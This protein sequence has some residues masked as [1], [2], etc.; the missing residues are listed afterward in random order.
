MTS[1]PDTPISL[2][3]PAE[4]RAPAQ[5]GVRT[6]AVLDVGA[7]AIRMEIAELSADGKV[8]TLESL[9]QPV[10][11]GKDTFTTGRIQQST[12][13]EC[14]KIL[15]GF[16]RVMEEYGVTEPSQ[17]RAVATSSVREAANREMFLDRIYMATRVNVEAIDEAE[18]TRLTYLAVQEVLEREPDLKRG[19]ALVI[20]VGGGDTELLLVQDGYVTY[21]NTFRLGTLRMRET[22]GAQNLAAGRILSTFTKHI[23]LTVDQIRRSVPVQ[24]APTLIALSGDARFAASQLVPDWSQVHL[25]RVDPKAFAAFAKKIA[26]VSPD[27]LVKQYRLTY[28]EAETVG[29][30]LLAFAQLAKVFGVDGILIPKSSL[31][32]GLLQEAVAGGLW[33]REFAE[34]VAHSAIALGTKYAFDERHARQVADLALRFF[35]ELQAEHMLPPRHELLL[36]VAALLHEIGLFVNNRS[37]HKHSMYLIMNS[38]LFGLSHFDMLMIAMIARY[39]RRATPQAYHEG[40]STLSRDARLAVSKMAA[41]LR[42]ADALDRNHMQQV[43][44][45]RFTREDGQFVVW[46][47][48][49]EDLTLERLALR[50]K[51]SM[52]EEVYGLKIVFRTESTAEGLVADV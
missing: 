51:G 25:A 1:S 2:P 40:F 32:Y 50:E 48:D 11:L 43:R 9:Q 3:A 22:L 12:I 37:H 24:K 4:P 23:Q 19:D 6:A 36:H 27:E 10:H 46:V 39:H 34:Q 18:E 5:P 8:R 15:K 42:V 21:A 44:D 52:F 29:P 30:A 13:E 49:V 31:R 28:Q 35:K 16:R 38:D 47:R 14:V 7:T 33:T 41:I 20:E 26:P 17:L 45:V